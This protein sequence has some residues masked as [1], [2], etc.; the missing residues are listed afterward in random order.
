[1]ATLSLIGTTPLAKCCISARKRF[2]VN[3]CSQAFR[4]PSAAGVYLSG[5]CYQCSFFSLNQVSSHDLNGMLYCK[6]LKSKI[7]QILY[8]ISKLYVK[9]PRAL[10]DFSA[11]YFPLDDALFPTFPSRT[12]NNAFV[13][14]E[15]LGAFIEDGH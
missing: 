9:F 7:W 12:T 5:H 13:P 11:Y 2:R 8:F 14:K 15:S 3:F 6:N 1:M 4:T 10:G